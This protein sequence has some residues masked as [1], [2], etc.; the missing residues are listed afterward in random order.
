MSRH[1]MPPARLRIAGGNPHLLMV[2][3]ITE[4]VRPP[5][6]LPAVRAL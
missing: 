5:R 4:L 2:C 3:A 1:A 6:A